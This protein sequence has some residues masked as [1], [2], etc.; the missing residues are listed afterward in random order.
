[1]TLWRLLI[2]R[3]QIKNNTINGRVSLTKIRRLMKAT[4]LKAVLD[5]PLQVLS[6]KLK[7]A[8]SI[9]MKACKEDPELR[10]KFMNSLDE[11]RYIED[12]TT[13]EAEKKKRA[14]IFSQNEAGRA[15]SR[16]KKN[17]R[18]IVSN[19]YSTTNGVRI[20]HTTKKS[21]EKAGIIENISRFRQVNNT[22]HMHPEITEWLG[23]YAESEAAN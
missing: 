19:V 10:G 11:A 9:Y 23:F 2:K 1:M 12:N 18:P 16:L 5:T 22:P 21:I 6:C 17:S 13:P 14:H 8:V 20:E 3:Q 15:L 4:N 7:G